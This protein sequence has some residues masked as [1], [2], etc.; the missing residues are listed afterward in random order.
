MNILPKWAIILATCILVQGCTPMMMAIDRSDANA[1]KHLLNSGTDPNDFQG[2]FPYLVWAAYRGEANIV[3][4]LLDKGADVNKRTTGN[5]KNSALVYAAEYNHPE[6]A[7][8][9]I[10]RGADV[11][12]AIDMLEAR[13][14]EAAAKA[15]VRFLRELKATTCT[16]RF[17]RD[18]FADAVFKETATKYLSMPV[19]PKLPEEARKLKVQAEELLREKKFRDAVERY[20]S[21]LEFA[22]WWPEGHFNRALILAECNCYEEAILEMHRYLQLAPEAS[23]SRAARDQIYKW[24]DKVKIGKP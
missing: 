2:D 21:A 12:Y 24:E 14:N 11:D 8:I 17:R 20:G 1:V 15:A 23:D 16:I 5:P 13:S 6:V 18:E 9:L 3:E 10:S 4:I 7:R 19:K 22:P